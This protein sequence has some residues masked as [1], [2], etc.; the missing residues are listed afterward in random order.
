MIITFGEYRKR[1]V[2]WLV[3]KRPDYVKWILERPAVAGPLAAVKAEVLR[4]VSIFDAKPILKPCS[5]RNCSKTAIRFSAYQG[6]SYDM[7]AWCEACDPFRFGAAPWKLTDIGTYNDALEFVRQKCD[8]RGPD[9]R[10]AID[11][12]ARAKGFPDRSSEA[13]IQRFFKE[14]FEPDPQISL[15]V[16]MACGRQSPA[17]PEKTQPDLVS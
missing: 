7:W 11:A 3:L 14:D 17:T 4:L 2:E 8:R 13:R 6:V 9:Y 5:G 1:S 10:A 16:A 12:I 15:A